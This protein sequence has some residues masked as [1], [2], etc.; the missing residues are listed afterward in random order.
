MTENVRKSATRSIRLKKL[1]RIAGFVNHMA[2]SLWIGRAINQ[3]FYRLI[4][5]KPKRSPAFR[6]LTTVAKNDL[7]YLAEL[8]RH[9]Q[10]VPLL[11]VSPS[12]ELPGHRVELFTDASLVGFGAVC[13]NAWLFG[14]WSQDFYHPDI[15]VLECATIAIALATLKDYLTSFDNP[16]MLRVDNQWITD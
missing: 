8:C 7:Y 9:P 2:D 13:N 10:W 1:E 3:K 4:N 14:G 11:Q 6:A 5:V 15:Q 12:Q 16:I